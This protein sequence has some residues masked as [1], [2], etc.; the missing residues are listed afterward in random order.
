MQLTVSDEILCEIGRV[1]V[2]H[3]HLEGE[4]AL[5]I[6]ELLRV[7]NDERGYILTFKMSF[8]EKV[9]VVRALL[10]NE[11]GD[12]HA[13]FIRFEAV[14]KKAERANDRRNNIAH[15]MWGFGKDFQSNAATRVK[16]NENKLADEA[17]TTNDLRSIA[18]ELQQLQWELSDIR[19]KL[20]HHEES[21]RKF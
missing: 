11:F 12:K 20:C 21:A 1:A 4:L 9:R 6:Q 17:L 2:S 3:S 16:A 19:A 5:F 7:A 15:S 14:R 13:E 8:G 10:R 18:Q